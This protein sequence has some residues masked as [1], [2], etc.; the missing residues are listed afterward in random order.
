MRYNWQ[1]RDWPEFHYDLT[2]IGEE[3]ARF[4]R[5]TERT[6]QAFH[7][8]PEKTRHETILDMMVTEA[9]KT[10]EIEGEYISRQDVMSSIRNQLGLNLEPERVHDLRAKGAAQLML[11]VRN[12]F[13]DKLTD[14]ML[15]NWHR[16]LLEDST[17]IAIGAWRTHE[18]P[19]QVVSGI[20]YKPT[21]HF[22]APPSKRVPQEMLSYI[23]WFNGAVSTTPSP[24]VRS[25]IAHLYFESIHPFEDGNGRIGRA[26][27][28]KVLSQGLGRPVLLSLSKAI[29]THK[30]DYYDALESAQKSNEITAWITYFAHMALGAQADTEA[31]IDFILKKTRFHDRYRNQLDKHQLKVINRMLDE[32]PK[33]FEGGMSAK[34]YSS[35]T[36]V[37]KAT[38]TRHLQQLKELG[39][40]IQKGSGR[41]TRYYV[42]LDD[43]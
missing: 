7:S 3:I 30:K 10:S 23:A 43:H 27:S 12:T 18:E 35:I 40:F 8:L 36:S 14:T 28:E 39:A 21:I 41:S 42:N 26:L 38:A 19:M 16:M 29:E 4:H 31:L 17:R 11:T 5:Q 20:T 13:E 1:Q 15:F 2:G 32:G 22:E 24:L 33:G 9:V 37:S 6:G 34:K 25:A